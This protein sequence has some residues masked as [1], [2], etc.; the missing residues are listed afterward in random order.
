MEITDEKK[1]VMFR[2]LAEKPLYEVGVKF[3]L[4]KHYA[5]AAS[6]KNKMY[7]IYQEVRKDPD[8]YFVSPDL[9]AT[10][11]TIVSNRGKEIAPNNGSVREQT[12]QAEADANDVSSLVLTGRIKAFK[13]LHKK[14]DQAGKSRKGL[15][16]ISLAQLATVSAILFDKGQ[17]VQGQATENVAVLAKID[18]NMSPEQAMETI[19]KMREINQAS[20]EKK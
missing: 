13:L 19:L 2:M 20:K 12:E 6:V 16:S 11:V 10:V 15:D 14:L 18:T 3:G 1:G 4:D 7:R 9:C 8:K 17:I 5:N